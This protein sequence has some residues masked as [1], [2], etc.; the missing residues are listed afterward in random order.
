[1]QNFG[2]GMW[3]RVGDYP[4]LNGQILLQQQ[5]SEEIKKYIEYQKLLKLQQALKLY[6][7]KLNNIDF[8]NKDNENVKSEIET[9]NIEENVLDKVEEL[10]N[11]ENN[12]EDIKPKSNYKH[13]FMNLSKKSTN[14]NNTNINKSNLR[15]I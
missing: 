14:N 15:K 5:R 8:N 6:Q 11:N 12:L 3:R 10:S 2:R 13:P 7:E 9:I 1:M 4:R